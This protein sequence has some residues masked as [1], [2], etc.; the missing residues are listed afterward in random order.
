MKLSAC[1]Y[2]ILLALLVACSTESKKYVIGV[3]QCSVDT[4]RAKFNDE[5]LTFSFLYDN[6]SVRIASAND[7]NTLQ[8]RQ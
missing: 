7:N 1:I 2:A 5:I 8:I 4:W 6:V 3:S